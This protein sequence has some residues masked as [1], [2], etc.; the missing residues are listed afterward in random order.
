MIKNLLTITLSFLSVFSFGQCDMDSYFIKNP[1]NIYPTKMLETKW[2]D[3]GEN[4]GALKLILRDKK[5]YINIASNLEENKN[6]DNHVDLI[7]YDKFQKSIRAPF[8][9]DD[10]F[11]PIDKISYKY[12]NSYSGSLNIL[13]FLS[14]K[15]LV[16]INETSTNKS[17]SISQNASNTIVMVS[18][19]FIQNIDTLKDIQLVYL[20]R[21]NDDCDYFEYEKDKFTGNVRKRLAYSTIGFKFQPNDYNSFALV[22]S[23]YNFENQTGFNIRVNSS[24]YCINDDSYVMIKLKNGKILKFINR[25]GIECDEGASYRCTLSAEDIKQLKESEIEVIRLMT[26]DGFMD[27]ENITKPKYFIDNID[28]L[29]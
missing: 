20:E 2:I 14:E 26:T 23:P 28:C 1:I 4:N 3:F 29:F 12:K 5:I 22:I 25:A 24:D 7:F 17:L 6:R 27:I 10:I 13:Q 18:N 16:N 19:C 8:K 9:G 11:E 21:R 15:K